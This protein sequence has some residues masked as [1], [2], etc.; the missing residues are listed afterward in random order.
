[1]DQ[2]ENLSR[3]YWV[4]RGHLVVQGGIDYSAKNMSTTVTQ[5]HVNIYALAKLERYVLSLCY[6]F[7]YMILYIL[8]I[9]G[10]HSAEVVSVHMFHFQNY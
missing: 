1:M 4:D 6:D 8:C 2:G 9:K 10:P 7:I 5:D 3:Q